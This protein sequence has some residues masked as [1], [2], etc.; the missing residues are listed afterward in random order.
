MVLNLGVD[1]YDSTELEDSLSREMEEMLGESVDDMKV[2]FR[3]QVCK[4]QDLYFYAD[5]ENRVIGVSVGS[6]EGL[7]GKA[8]DIVFCSQTVISE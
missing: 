6:R 3:S 8:S 5:N 7:H 2:R 4:G 1:V